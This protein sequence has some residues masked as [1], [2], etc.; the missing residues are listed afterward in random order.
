MQGSSVCCRRD[1]AAGEADGAGRR[2]VTGEAEPSGNEVMGPDEKGV[3]FHTGRD[4]L[5]LV[6]AG[7]DQM[8]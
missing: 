8:L 1:L 5:S 6:C 3:T 7:R 2:R 4:T